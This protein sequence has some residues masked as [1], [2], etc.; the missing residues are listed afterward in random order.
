MIYWNNSF[1]NIHV[2]I[3][4]FG[5]REIIHFF[6]IKLHFA[7]KSDMWQACWAFVAV[8]FSR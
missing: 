5:H 7:N 1:V 2:F 8:E 3:P 4:K 6:V